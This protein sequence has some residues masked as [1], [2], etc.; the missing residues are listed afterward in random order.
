MVLRSKKPAE[1]EQ[2]GRKH[3]FC[4]KTQMKKHMKCHYLEEH[5][6]KCNHC[7]LSVSSKFQLMSAQVLKRF[8]AIVK[9]HTH[10]SQKSLYSVCLP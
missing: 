1:R 10:Y 3:V 2:I 4:L 9:E 7:L 8:A 5:P 6:Y